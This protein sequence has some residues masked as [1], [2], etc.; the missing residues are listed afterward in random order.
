MRVRADGSGGV[1]VPVARGADGLRA[2]HG[3]Q[4]RAGQGAPKYMERFGAFA[5]MVTLVW[6]YMEILRLLSKARR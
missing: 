5:L 1:A 2:G 4:L 3:L 6:L